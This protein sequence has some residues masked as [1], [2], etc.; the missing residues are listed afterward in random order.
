MNAQEENF[1]K[2]L[3]IPGKLQEWQDKNDP[4][5]PGPRKWKSQKVYG[6][7]V[8]SETA[9]RGPKKVLKNAA[10]NPQTEVPRQ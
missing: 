8:V 9:R 1:R 4:A 6:K 10:P 3:A 2:V 7:G 5:P